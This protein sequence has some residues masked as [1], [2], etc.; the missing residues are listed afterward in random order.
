MR[1]L[2][3]G[4]LH[5]VPVL[6]ALAGLGRCTCGDAVVVEDAAVTDG[7]ALQDAAGTDAGLQ[8]DTAR[9][10]V[11]RRPDATSGD[12]ALPD[13]ALPPPSLVVQLDS[14]L[15]DRVRARL[16]DLLQQASP[17]PLRVVDDPGPFTGQGDC[18]IIA[19][20]DVWAVRQLLPA[21]EVAALGSEGFVLRSGDINGC[22]ALVGDGNALQPDPFGHAP[23]GLVYAAYAALELLG[24]GFLHPLAPVTPESF[25]LGAVLID[26]TEAPHWP[27]RGL[28]IHT[29]HPLELTDL[30]QGFGITGP[31]DALGFEAMLPEWE[32][33]A[34][35]LVANRQ[36][37][38]HWPLLEATPWQD[39]S[40]GP[41]RQQRLATLVELAQ[42]YGV[43]VGAD[44]PVALQ[45][46]H[47]FRLL[48]SSGS[49][50]DEKAEIR[51]SLDWLMGA[52]FD[53]LATE[54]GSTEFTHPDP[55]RM[56]A[57]LDEVARY[58]DEQYGKPAVIKVHCS[59]GQVADGYL[60]QDTGEPLNFNFLPAYADPRLGV[61]PHS[62]QIYGL[63]DPAP[64]Y[65]NTDFGYM[66]TFMQQQ[67][68]RRTVLWHPETAY[69]VSYDVDVPLFL[70]VYA[71]RRV[72]D[73]RLIADDE[74][75]GRTGRGEHAG[76]HID[77]Q[78]T[79]S[80]GWEWG[81]WLNDVVT[82]RAAWDP[83]T[84]ATDDA[85]ALHEILGE[86]LAP[87]GEARGDLASVLVD[88]ATTQHA[89]LVLGRVQG[90]DPVAIERRSGMAYLQGFDA[91]DDVMDLGQGLP[92]VGHI[93][94]QPD[95]LGLVEMRNPLHAPPSYSNELK[96][97]FE[98]MQRTLSELADRYVPL[99]PL[100]AAP[101]I[102][103]IEDLG[104]ASRITA[105]RA[106]QIEN[107]YA[108]VADDPNP[109][110]QA[111]AAASLERARAALD[112]AQALV[113]AREPHYRVHADRAAGWYPGPTA[114]AYR[115]LWTVRTLL[116]WWRD[117]HKAV[118]APT[119]P[120]TLNIVN[121]ATVGLGEGVYAD[122]ARLA[123][124][125]V[126]SV[127]L[128]GSLSECL[129]EP[130]TEP[131]MPPAGLRDTP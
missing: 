23:L 27:V 108:F 18:W 46:Q 62:V 29:M 53:Y 129:A 76:A 131:V 37:R 126:D 96:P 45:Q 86:V 20:G 109:L 28:Q 91:W 70:P 50:D 60:D 94:T 42:D 31:D 59:Q 113:A 38:V 1:L 83:H 9:F 6:V 110:R 93:T 103:L 61:A 106:T 114:Y 88:T 36:N 127:P 101:S 112:A 100:A 5:R 72:H 90:Q 13:A 48:R 79:F 55:D 35:W 125:L 87:F 63:D 115:Y 26:R 67:A 4:P 3:P 22:A 130:G 97:L 82:A 2:R 122:A 25:D 11:A 98:E 24:Y 104:D 30:L 65:G 52:G 92:L 64:T 105:L 123:Q 58:L 78:L 117:E 120:C 44:A 121:P 34:E 124:D 33:V 57:W 56:L 39:F 89:L 102:E 128:V 14:E 73:L 43:A 71:Y 84:A 10:D 74:A 21:A 75:Q 68:G 85:T 16:I 41:I 32:R 54:N 17:R 111:E 81:N 15:S 118:N 69:W 107:L 95:K 12:S 49:L 7:S 119:N 77:G 19:M 80:S 8:A 66:R 99:I 116:Y 47:T 51:S 40:R